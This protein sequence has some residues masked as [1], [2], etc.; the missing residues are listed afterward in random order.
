MNKTKFKTAIISLIILVFFIINTVPV[1]A[2]ETTSSSSANLK[3]LGITP[4]DFSG[5]KEN[6]TTYNVTVPNNVKS[7]NVYATAKESSAKVE[8]TGKLELE[9]GKNKAQVVVTAKDGTTKKY[10]INIKRLKEGESGLTSNI[11]DLDENLGLSKLEIKGCT[12]EPSFDKD[13]HQYTVEVKDKT[14]SLKID[15]EATIDDANIIVKGNTNLIKGQNIVTI[16]VTDSNENSVSIYQL[17]VNNQVAKPEEID[18][19][20]NDAQISMNVKKWI[21]IFFGIVIIVCLLM[22][23]RI[24]RIKI[25]LKRNKDGRGY[26]EY[27]E[28]EDD[29]Y[30]EEKISKNKNNNLDNNESRINGNTQKNSVDLMEN[31]EKEE[32]SKSARQIR[33]NYLKINS[34]IENESKRRSKKAKHGRHSK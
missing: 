29:Y 19:H 15:A 4:N 22:L 1:F 13:V 30:E 25:A 23:K 5:F 28:D 6:T 21:T 12:I 8:G 7:V 33:E 31:E 34:R 20:Y 9:E 27:E 24:I 11:N 10:T 17:Y 18:G 32:L 14:N 3:M 16:F 2:V 26:E